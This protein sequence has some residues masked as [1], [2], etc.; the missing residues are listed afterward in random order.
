MT[1]SISLQQFHALTHPL[2]GLPIS[3]AREG[4]YTTALL[5]LGEL[6]ERRFSRDKTVLEGEASFMLEWHWRVEKEKVIWFSSHSCETKREEGLASLEG[7]LVCGITVE[8]RLPELV[9]ELSD[10]IWIKSFNLAEEQPQW[11]VFLKEGS[12][13]LSRFGELELVLE[14]SQVRSD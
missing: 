6:K 8:G 7:K 14:S 5:Y 1:P 3:R 2:I 4:Y 9:I 12:W 13:I 10:D 11:T